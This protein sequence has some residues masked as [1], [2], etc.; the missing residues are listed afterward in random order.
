MEQRSL[1]DIV[2]ESLKNNSDDNVQQVLE[3]LDELGVED[4]S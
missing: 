1:H 4:I 2:K 3:K